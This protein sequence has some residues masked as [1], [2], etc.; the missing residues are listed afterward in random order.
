MG[1]AAAVLVVPAHGFIV[2]GGGIVNS[3]APAASPMPTVSAEPGWIQSFLGACAWAFMI[4]AGSLVY[5][6]FVGKW[7]AKG[8]PIL[9]MAALTTQDN[10]QPRG[11]PAIPLGSSTNQQ[12]RQAH[13][14]QQQQ[15]QGPQ[16]VPSYLDQYE[17]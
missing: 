1:I 13:R 14:Q 5:N 6:H 10:P 16:A 8:L 11:G 17:G 15:Q 9:P 4:A 3:T 7:T 12:Q 2:S